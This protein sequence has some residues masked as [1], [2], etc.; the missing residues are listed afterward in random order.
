MT[1]VREIGKN[2]DEVECTA[3]FSELLELVGQ[4]FLGQ[5]DIDLCTASVLDIVIE[6]FWF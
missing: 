5:G 6:F 4:V 1:R 3:M 2:Q